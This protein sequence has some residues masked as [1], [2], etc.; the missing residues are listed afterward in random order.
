[1]LR[2]R[3]LGVAVDCVD[4]PGTL[5]R[6]D[7]WV[8]NG[9]H[10]RQVA[11][12]NPEF[13]MRAL[14]DSAFAAA[15]EQADLC[16][17]DGSG[18]LWAI[19]REGCGLDRKVAG[20]DLVPAL[21]ERAAARG[22]RLF[23]LGAGAGVA[24]EAARRLVAANP[25]LIV[26]GVH[27]GSPRPEDDDDSLALIAASGA[28]VLLVAYGA[29]AQDIWIARNRARLTVRVAVGVGGTLDFVAG[30][31]RRAPGWMRRLHLEWLYRL[32]RQPWRARR[33]AVLPV[34]M[35]RVL[36]GGHSVASR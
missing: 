18:V 30:R 36:A 33:M 21:A 2:V 4:M 5:G 1:M 15:L 13:V 10:C 29:P 7:A 32:I 19:R 35:V 20:S 12:I 6:V 23:L 22:H 24:A 11:T 34:Y 17:A 16:L 14:R 3:V 9:G 28:D 27:S 8:E 25:A 31:V 26:A